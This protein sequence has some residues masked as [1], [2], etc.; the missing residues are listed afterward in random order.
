MQTKT[1]T[2][3]RTLDITQRTTDPTKKSGWLVAR[4]GRSGRRSLS[5]LIKEEPAAA[6]TTQNSDMT[7]SGS[8]TANREGRYLYFWRSFAES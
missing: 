3:L 7:N 5:L 1:V 4:F 6:I 8:L 2:V